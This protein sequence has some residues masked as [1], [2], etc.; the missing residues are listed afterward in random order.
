VREGQQDSI[1]GAA[2]ALRPGAR[3]ARLRRPELTIV[4]PTRNEQDVVGAFIDSLDAELTGVRAELIIVDDSD[5]DTPAVVAERGA[6]AGLEVAIIHR[7]P[8]E[9]DGGLGGAVVAGIAA[10]RPPCVM[11]ADLQHPPAEIA[12]LRTQA[13]KEKS[14]LVIASRFLGGGSIEGLSTVR[15]LISRALVGLAR[16]AFPFRLRSVSDPLTGFFLVRR[17]ALDLAA[18][19][20]TASRSCSRSSSARRSSRSRKS[21]SSSGSGRRVRARRRC[22]RCSGTSDSSGGSAWARRRRASGA[23]AS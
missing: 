10:A 1:E 5:D 11:D 20:R 15:T 7:P 19:A 14:D 13:A 18:C 23:S 21:R 3:T 2:A 12:A 8:G 16:V 4:A 9:R 22:E 17:S 6:A